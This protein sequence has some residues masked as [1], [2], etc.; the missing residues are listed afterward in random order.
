MPRIRVDLFDVDCAAQ[1]NKKPS[2]VGACTK[3]EILRWLIFIEGDFAITQ[4]VEVAA[5]AVPPAVDDGE[6]CFCGRVAFRGRW[7]A[8]ELEIG[9]RVFVA[10]MVGKDFDLGARGHCE[11][12]DS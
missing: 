9:P 4:L 10:V 1:V 6:F 11:N 12:Q 2:T 7:N 3:E 5:I 8:L